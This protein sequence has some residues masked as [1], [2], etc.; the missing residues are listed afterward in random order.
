MKKYIV[1]LSREER[2]DLHHLIAQGQASARKL[3]HARILLKADS[4]EA[5]PG[6][7]DQTISEALEVGT[8]TIERVRERFVEEGLEASLTRHRPRS[9]RLRK[10][11]GEQEARLIALVCSPP[12]E[13]QECWTLQ[14]LAD[15]LV[16]LHI[17]ESIARETIRQVLKNL[18]SS[19]GSKRSG[20]FRPRA[21]PSSSV[22]LKRSCRC[23]RDLTMSG[24]LR[25]VW[26][27]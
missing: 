7:S 23:T 26:M 14:L 5:G 21:M 22:K 25:Y 11:D 1:K 20:A 12:D 9:P 16:E 4:G 17:V 10:L 6:W 24:I 3:A 18:N 15:K 27:R 19:P 8:A 13:G 2:T